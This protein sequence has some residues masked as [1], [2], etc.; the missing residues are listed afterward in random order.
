MS[1]S[2]AS[3][4]DEEDINIFCERSDREMIFNRLW[5]KIRDYEIRKAK[6]LI[7]ENEF[8]IY[9]ICSYI[10]WSLL[11]ISIVNNTK[12]ITTFLLEKMEYDVLSSKSPK[13]TLMHAIKYTKSYNIPLQIVQKFNNVNKKNFKNGKTAL[14][15]VAEQYYEVPNHQ[16]NLAKMLLDHG[17]DPMIKDNEDKTPIDIVRN[18]GN[19]MMVNLLEQYVK[20]DFQ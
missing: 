20:S 14:H 15:Y 9:E 16:F 13:T 10:G 6:Q 4:D 12:Q 3:S 5:D 11:K 2:S 19:D 17:A 7:N 8:V 18:D 1:A